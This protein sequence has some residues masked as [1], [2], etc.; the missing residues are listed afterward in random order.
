MFPGMQPL[1]ARVRGGRLVLDEPTDLPEGT[2]VELMLANDVEGEMS[3]EER[4]ALDAEIDAGCDEA[5]E[6][7]G[8]DADVVI[9]RMEAL[10]EARR[11]KTSA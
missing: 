8:E 11:M 4:Q 6:G 7:L 1:K 10:V 9:A 2:E 5:D 3:D